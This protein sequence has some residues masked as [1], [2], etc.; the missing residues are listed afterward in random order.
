MCHMV[1]LYDIFPRC[2]LNSTIVGK[3][4]LKMC[5]FDFLYRFF[6]EMFL[7]LRK[8]QQGIVVNVQMCLCKVSI[9]LLKFEWNLNFLNR[10]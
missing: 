3:G 8:I 4:L 1:R 2:S 9:I 5:V 7:I 6:S 10:F